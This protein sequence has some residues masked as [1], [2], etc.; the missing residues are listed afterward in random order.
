M[1]SHRDPRS[2]LLFTL[3]LLVLL[4]YR[5]AAAEPRTIDFSQ[6]VLPILSDNCFQCHGPDVRARKAK[7]RLDTQD[8]ALRKDD[9]V[10]VSGKSAESELIH[11]ISSSDADMVMPPV[12][13]NKKLTPRQ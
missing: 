5:A 11:R 4:S 6:D 2:R 10:I 1:T 8:G 9:P 7:L 13:S 12:K 3:P